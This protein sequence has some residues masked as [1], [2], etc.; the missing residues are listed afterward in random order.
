MFSL[1]KLWLYKLIF[2]N[3]IIYLKYRV[4]GSDSESTTGRSILTAPLIPMKD[5]SMKLKFPGLERRKFEL[6]Q[7]FETIANETENSE[8]LRKSNTELD[9]EKQKIGYFSVRPKEDNPFGYRQIRIFQLY[10]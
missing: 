1:K 8:N 4:S 6:P 10:N 7:K 9:I 2:L 5:I 3:Y